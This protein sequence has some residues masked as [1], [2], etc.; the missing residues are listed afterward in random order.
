MKPIPEP[1]IGATQIKFN[2]PLSVLHGAD[3]LDWGNMR[4]YPPGKLS[5]RHGERRL[6]LRTLPLHIPQKYKKRKSDTHL[7]PKGCYVQLNANP[8]VI[9]Q[10][11]QQS[12]DHLLWKGMCHAL[13]LTQYVAH[14]TMTNELCV[15]TRDEVEYAI[16]VAILEYISPDALHDLCL[17]PSTSSSSPYNELSIQKLTKEEGMAV[18]ME[19]LKKDAVVLDDDDDDNNGKDSSTTS[20]T[21]ADITLT[22]SLLCSM[23]MTAMS[24]PVRGKKCRHMQCFDLRNYL[25]TNATVS[26]GRWRCGVC[27]DFVPVDDLVVD[28]MMVNMLEEIG[29][30]K[31]SGS[32]D[33]IQMSKNGSWKFMEENRLRYGGKKRS[34]AD[35]EEEENSQKK[36]KPTN[37]V[38]RQESEIIELI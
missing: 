12:H 20:T 14:P 22:F 38:A 16:Q 13:D 31:I 26:G 7:W 6:L 29:K 35:G 1:P 11:K 18:A 17:A 36:T 37:G 19:Y 34:T 21:P 2:I 23:S 10:R 33:K 30:D 8:V 9:A 28:G 24:T 5:Y 32:R 3:A 4:P 25:H 15:C 27:E